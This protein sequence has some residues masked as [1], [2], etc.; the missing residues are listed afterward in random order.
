[1]S[2]H[3]SANYSQVPPAGPIH[4][5]KDL[6][7][8][9][10]DNAAITKYVMEMRKKLSIPDS[11]TGRWCWRCGAGLDFPGVAPYHPAG[12]CRALP[13]SDQVHYCGPPANRRML[14]AARDCPFKDKRQENQARKVNTI[15]L[16]YPERK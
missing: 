13:S 14:H 16:S 11:D 4:N 6:Y 10:R 15:R 3:G 1:M 5:P 8:Q 7:V 12:K 2:R 9:A